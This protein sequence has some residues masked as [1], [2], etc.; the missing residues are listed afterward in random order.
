MSTPST[1]PVPTQ[2]PPPPLALTVNLLD[3]LLLRDD[4]PLGARLDLTEVFADLLDVRPPFP[5]TVPE[6]TAATGPWATVATQVEAAL[7]TLSTD[8]RGDVPPAV[9]LG[10][11][12]TARRVRDT[13]ARHDP[14]AS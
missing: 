13:V 6:P 8:T 14:A 11:A 4:L 2:T 10:Y 1:T 5:P 9:V 12:L 7:R 3:G